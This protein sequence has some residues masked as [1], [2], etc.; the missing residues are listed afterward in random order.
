MLNTVYERWRDDI[1]EIVCMKAPKIYKNHFHNHLEIALCN[2]DNKEM[3]ISNEKIN[4]KKGQ[5]LIIPPFT[6]HCFLESEGWALL[7]LIP[8]RNLGDSNIFFNISKGA[9]HMFDVHEQFEELQTLLLN[10]VKNENFTNLKKLGTLYFAMAIISEKTDVLKTEH[11]LQAD[12]SFT[13]KMIDYIYENHK[14]D[15]KIT[16]LAEHCNY[17]RAYVSSKFNTLFG[18]SF[19]D[20]L[21][22]IRLNGFCENYTKTQGSIESKALAQGFQTVRSFYNTFKSKYGVTPKVYFSRLI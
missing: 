16:D 3:I 21:A 19:S 13:Q 22:I 4:L 2:K 12:T 18:C 17:S 7:L 15:I 14:K 1:D 8:R 10:G 11:H 5:C 20:Y 6:S 9:Y